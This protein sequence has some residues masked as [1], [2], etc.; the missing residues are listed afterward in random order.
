M[1]AKATYRA[2]VKFDFNAEATFLVA[3]PNLR[4]VQIAAQNASGAPRATSA[5]VVDFSGAA[6]S[7]YANGAEIPLPQTGEGATK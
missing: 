1:G 5:Y 6:V 3:S 2:Y 7:L 4:K